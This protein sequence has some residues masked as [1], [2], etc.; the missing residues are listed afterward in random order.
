MGDLGSVAS[1][2]TGAFGF[3]AGVLGLL[4]PVRLQ[5]RAGLLGPVL[6]AFPALLRPVDL[7]RSDFFEPASE[8]VAEGEG[9]AILAGVKASF[10][11]GV[12]EGWAGGGVTCVRT[13]GILTEAG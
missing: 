10:G 5:L 8:V 2:C 6:G 13:T 3:N 12:L 9:V 7:M 11:V 4:E 1:A